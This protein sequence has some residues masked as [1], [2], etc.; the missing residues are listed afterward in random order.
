MPAGHPVRKEEEGGRGGTRACFPAKS[1]PLKSNVWKPQP[2][3]LISMP[4]TKEAGTCCL[5]AGHVA[6]LNK[7][8]VLLVR[9]K[10]RMDV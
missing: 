5:L 7:I 10:E 8:S 2:T 3:P 9:K 1:V 4:V 6:T